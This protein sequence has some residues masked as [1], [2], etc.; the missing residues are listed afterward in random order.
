MTTS[1]CVCIKLPHIL[2]PRDWPWL[3]SAALLLPLR[4]PL[5]FGFAHELAVF[6]NPAGRRAAR[7][8]HRHDRLLRAG[9]HQSR[10]SC[11]CL[12]ETSW[13]VSPMLTERGQ[14]VCCAKRTSEDTC[15][16]TAGRN[17]VLVGRSVAFLLPF[18]ADHTSLLLNPSNRDL[19]SATQ[20]L[21]DFLR[22]TAAPREASLGSGYQ[23]RRLLDW[24]HRINMLGR[25]AHEAVLRPAA[26]VQ[27]TARLP[28]APSPAL[29]CP[30]VARLRPI[31]FRR[32]SGGHAS[33]DRRVLMV[34]VLM[35][36][37]SPSA[38]VVG[39]SAI[40]LDAQPAR[41]VHR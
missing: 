10:Y 37:A 12:D 39:P 38:L 41:S 23:R 21:A 27:Q 14:K 13:S 20:L 9:L 6:A 17:S 28:C 36:Q 34:V 22:V 25:V 7:Q 26:G 35:R 1:C 2:F 16:K 4:F 11:Q 31:N 24:R 15:Q 18:R 19:C 30:A 32:T 40:Q 8:L 33:V 5:S 3:V 29:G